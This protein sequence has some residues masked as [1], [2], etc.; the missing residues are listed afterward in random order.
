MICLTCSRLH[1]SAWR[2]LFFYHA[3]HRHTPRL[4]I[5]AVT[6]CSVVGR[7]TENHSCKENCFPINVGI[8]SLTQLQLK[9]RRSEST[10]LVNSYRTIFRKHRLT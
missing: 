8:T 4:P 5:S 2:F 10:A 9:R 6:L 7:D 3:A 1:S